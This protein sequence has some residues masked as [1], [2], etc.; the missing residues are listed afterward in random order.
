MIYVHCIHPE[1][2]QEFMG[3]EE[4]ES[5]VKIPN[6]CKGLSKRFVDIQ[7]LYIVDGI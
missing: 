5:S 6:E 3:K 4:N 1:S 2:L 7:Y